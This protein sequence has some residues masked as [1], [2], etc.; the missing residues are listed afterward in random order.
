MQY[1]YK[2]NMQLNKLLI[3]LEMKISI[4]TCQVNI[5]KLSQ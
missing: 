3:M 1:K 5:S 4:I 2:H